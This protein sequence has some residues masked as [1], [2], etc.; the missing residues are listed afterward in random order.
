MVSFSAGYWTIGR[1]IQALGLQGASD[2]AG[3]PLLFLA[4]LIVGLILMPLQ[5]A[6][7]RHREMHA[8]LFA[9]RARPDKA[10]F[11]SCMERLGKVNLAEMDP[12]AWYEWLFY[13][14]PSIRKR[15]QMAEKQTTDQRL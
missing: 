3:L 9:L 12:P 10:V 5:N 1:S 2:I 7:S 14:H 13:D 15:I 4:F 11:I 6:F 8:D